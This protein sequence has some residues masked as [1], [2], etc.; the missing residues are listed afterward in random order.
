MNSLACGHHPPSTNAHRDLIAAPICLRGLSMP[1]A[2]MAAGWNH[3][4]GR[5]AMSWYRPPRHTLAAFMSAS[6]QPSMVMLPTSAFQWAF[7]KWPPPV[8]RSE[9]SRAT[10]L[11]AASAASMSVRAA[12]V[13]VMTSVVDM[14]IQIPSLV[15][16]T[17]NEGDRQ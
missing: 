8:P 7:L 1:Q 2:I 9:M 6:P 3:G 17:L 15:M 16:M 5:P 4:T 12:R 13:M 11:A 14:S 10:V